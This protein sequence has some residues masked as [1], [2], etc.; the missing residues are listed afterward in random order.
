MDFPVIVG[1]SES[2]AI[3]GIGMQ[4]LLSQFNYFNP[5]IFTSSTSRKRLRELP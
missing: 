4:S 2:R 1:G 5:F 3:I